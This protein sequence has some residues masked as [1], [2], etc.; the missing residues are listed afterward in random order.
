MCNELKLV[1]PMHMTEELANS[2]NQFGSIIADPKPDTDCQPELCSV[3]TRYSITGCFS[4]DVLLGRFVLTSI[5]KS[6][7]LGKI[8]DLTLTNNSLSL[9]LLKPKVDIQL[10]YQ[11]S[12]VETHTRFLCSRNYDGCQ[13]SSKVCGC[14]AMNKTVANIL[15]ESCR[16]VG[17]ELDLQVDKKQCFTLR[18]NPL[19]QQRRHLVEFENQQPFLQEHEVVDRRIYTRIFQFPLRI[20]VKISEHAPNFNV[21]KPRLVCGRILIL[22]SDSSGKKFRFFNNLTDTA[23]L[24]IGLKFWEK[25]EILCFEKILQKLFK[26]FCFIKWKTLYHLWR[27]LPKNKW[28]QR[29]KLSANTLVRLLI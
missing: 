18:E 2:G 14:S 8:C 22:P 13:T 24:V 12:V 23:N 27:G 16:S 28:I 1:L 11:G 26:F 17:I 3:F 5:E 19:A 6:D 29:K 10:K 20:N 4:S 25:S 15:A 7:D 21:F 9:F